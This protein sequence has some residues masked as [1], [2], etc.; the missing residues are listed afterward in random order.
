MARRKPKPV[1]RLV[2][3]F[4]SEQK[5]INNIVCRSSAGDATIQDGN[6]SAKKICHEFKP[7]H[8]A[9]KQDREVLVIRK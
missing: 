1:S 9:E 2:S 8:T 5:C 7:D 4:C 3:V 6:I